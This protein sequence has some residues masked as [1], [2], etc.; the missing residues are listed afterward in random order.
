MAALCS[1]AAV[2]FSAVSAVVS[3]FTNGL[4]TKAKKTGSNSVNK[5]RAKRRKQSAMVRIAV[6]TARPQIFAVIRTPW[7]KQ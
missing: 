4:R 7:E 6:K 2:D 5:K 3:I 1:V